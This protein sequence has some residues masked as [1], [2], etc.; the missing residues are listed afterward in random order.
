MDNPGSTPSR[1]GGQ[2]MRTWSP[3]RSTL[4]STC[5]DAHGPITSSALCHCARCP[6]FRR[7][8]RRRQRLVTARIGHF[9]QLAAANQRAGC[10]L[11]IH[12]CTNGNLGHGAGAFAI[13]AGPNGTLGVTG[14]V[15]G[16][17]VKL[18]FQYST[19]W[20][21]TFT[22]SLAAPGVLKGAFVLTGASPAPPSSVEFDRT[23]P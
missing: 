11:S 18:V 17:D 21:G 6:R 14:A 5:T 4:T 23:A 10:A 3:K 19:G 22:G 20:T 13:E 8:L 12:G 1:L 15:Q 2:A 9:G 7:R 16:S